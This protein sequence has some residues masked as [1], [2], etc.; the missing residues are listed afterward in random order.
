MF[1]LHYSFVT[2]CLRLFDAVAAMYKTIIAFVIVPYF[3]VT[4][5]C[6][7]CLVTM[8]RKLFFFSLRNINGKILAHTLEIKKHPKQLNLQRALRF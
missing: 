7:F 2:F 6:H 1:I 4:Y 3:S 5:N 8:I